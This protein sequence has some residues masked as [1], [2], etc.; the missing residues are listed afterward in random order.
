MSDER[1]EKPAVRRTGAA[2]RPG[3]VGRRLARRREQM[4]V[5]R[6]ELGRRAGVAPEYVRYVEERPSDVD[7]RTL[8]K[9]ARALDITVVRLL[10]GGP[11]APPGPGRAG[12]AP[13]FS[14]LTE[15]ECRR[16][17]DR[18]GIGRLALTTPD[19]P[20]AFPVNYAVIGGDVVY[21]TRPDAVVAPPDGTPAGFQ[22]DQIDDAFSEGWSVLIAGTVRHVADPAA[23]RE[24]A[25]DTEPEPWAGG[26]RDLW[27]RIEPR[28]IT[29]R[30]IRASPYPSDQSDAA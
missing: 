14:S 5:S 8:V 27:I 11:G 26:P 21:R 15:E 28:K 1:A 23:L 2:A 10:G 30:R 24:E 29:G 22:V 18:H 6:E 19:G 25:G 7:A 20:A 13:E 3:D 9:L 4:G 12:G 16:L 17:L